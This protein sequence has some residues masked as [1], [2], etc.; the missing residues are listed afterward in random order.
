MPDTYEEVKK[1]VVTYY[2]GGTSSYEFRA[3]IDLCRADNTLIAVLYF[4]RD[5]ARMPAVD[6][7]ASSSRSF[8]WCF[9]PD[10]DFQNVLDLLR[11]EKPVYF[12]YITG[13]L[14]IGALT[15]SKEPVGEEE[16]SLLRPIA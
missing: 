4:Y 6:D 2:A 11:N 12:R 8:A 7:Q 9:F 5:P 14:N 13:V 3:S 1:Y 15:T 10:R 16:H